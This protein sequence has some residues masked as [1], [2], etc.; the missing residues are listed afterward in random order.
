MKK[1]IDLKNEDKEKKGSFIKRK[2]QIKKKVEE[3]KKN[4]QKKIKKR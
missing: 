3:K 2:R 1:D 4:E